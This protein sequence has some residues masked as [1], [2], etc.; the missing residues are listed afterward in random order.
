MAPQKAVKATTRTRRVPAEQV[1]AELRGMYESETTD[2]EE[3]SLDF[4]S[5]EGTIEPV[6]RENL[7]KHKGVWYTIP[8]EFGP[9]VGLVYL[10]RV[11][12]GGGRDEA[13]GTILK[14]VIGPKGWAAL[15]E[16]AAEDKI[17]LAQMKAIMVKVNDRTMGALEDT[18]G[19]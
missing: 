15:L 6:E 4:D 2:A 11:S 9:G 13:L 16:L 18:E 10:D 12:N 7:F 1:P 19:N 17:S 8:K 5:A 14:T 3:V